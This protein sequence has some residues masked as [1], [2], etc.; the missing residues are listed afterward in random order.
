MVGLE[1]LDSDEELD[2]IFAAVNH[3]RVSMTVSPEEACS[4]PS[5]AVRMAKVESM[6][7]ILRNDVDSQTENVGSLFQIVSEKNTY[8]S[9]VAGS[10]PHIET[11][12]GASPG[13]K[14]RPTGA[15]AGHRPQGVH[16]YPNAQ[17]SQSQQNEPSI[18]EQSA[19]MN[20]DGFQRPKEQIRQED[21]SKR[22][23]QRLIRG[24]KEDG[25]LKSEGT[26]NVMVKF[27]AK[28]YENEDMKKYVNDEGVEVHSVETVSNPSAKTKS[29][30]IEI[31]YKDKD[32][33]LSEDFWPV[34]IGFKIWRP[35]R[36][37]QGAHL[38]KQHVES[39]RS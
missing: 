1:N 15:S 20:E 3:G 21:R 8:A 31:N 29:F 33:V 17:Q 26:I 2:P 27:L 19:V 14:T 35:R 25:R 6:L 10:T 4:T 24:R 11:P 18:V 16:V 13:R 12:G 37:G 34:G 32:K 30:K 5:L 23:V 38:A 9:K 22:R 39:N 7:K 36:E 28:Q